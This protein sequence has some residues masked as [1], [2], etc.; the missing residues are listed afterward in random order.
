MS[1]DD[2]CD[3]AAAAADKMITVIMIDEFKGQRCI[4]LCVVVLCWLGSEETCMVRVYH[5]ARQPLKNHLSW[6]LGGWT[7]PWS[8]E[9]MLDGQH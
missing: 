6:H 4:L 5:K 7:K 3:S 1:D 9:E 2:E 8:A